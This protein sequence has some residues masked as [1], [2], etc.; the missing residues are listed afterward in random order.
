MLAFL[1]N[2]P[3]YRTRYPLT[4]K[5]QGEGIG[6]GDV[7]AKYAKPVTTVQVNIHVGSK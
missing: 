4:F 7:C 2:M 6:G 1:Q 3:Y 5:S